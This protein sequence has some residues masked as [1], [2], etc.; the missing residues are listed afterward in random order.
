MAAMLSLTL[1][2]CDADATGDAA[3]AAA[4][5]AGPTKLVVL[6]D[7]AIAVQPGSVEEQLARYLASPAPAPRL[8]R[9]GGGEFQPWQS[10]PD[11]ATLRTMYAVQQIL[12]AYPKV[13]VT[14]VGHTDTDGTPERNLALS[15]QRAEGMARLLVEG[16]I[17]PRRITTVGKGMAQPI[18]SNA[19]E[20]GRAR[21]RR[22]DLIV[23]TK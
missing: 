7:S 14:L 19:S 4:P 18:A 2:G 22:I 20:A 15:R 16:G 23:T 17:A 5:Q 12:R 10:R 8:F 1:G 9:F 6:P 11:P 3:V 21:N 13:T